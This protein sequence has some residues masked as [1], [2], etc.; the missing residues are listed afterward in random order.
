MCFSRTAARAAAFFFSFFALVASAEPLRILVVGDSITQGGQANRDERTYRL[1]LQALLR[2]SRIEADFV[3]TRRE[4]VDSSP[5]VAWPEWFDPDHEAYYGMTAAFVRD[6]LREHLPS[7][8]APDVV[9][10][11]LG[12][13]DHDHHLSFV[14]PLED[15]ITLVRAKNPR[16]TVLVGHLALNGWRARLERYRINR[17]VSRLDSAQSRVVAVDHFDGWKN[18]PGAPDALTYD[19]VHPNVMGQY[20]MALRWFAAMRP[21][22]QASRSTAGSTRVSGTKPQPPQVP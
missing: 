17:M 22:L 10:I 19:A 2:D 8:P 14:E 11:H 21:F 6:R 20:T 18:D 13:N 5:L 7:L 12:T 16:V 9:L 3:G 15:I 1:P 4:G